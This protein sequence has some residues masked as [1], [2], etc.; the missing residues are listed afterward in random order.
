MVCQAE[1]DKIKKVSL[2]E[3][4]ENNEVSEICQSLVRGCL[5]WIK[6]DQEFIT[7]VAFP[8]NGRGKKGKNV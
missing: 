5:I 4:L 8:P 2:Q 3:S 7:F 1:Y 6:P